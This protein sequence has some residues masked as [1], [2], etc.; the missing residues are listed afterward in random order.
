VQS[1]LDEI[2]AEDYLLE[3]LSHHTLASV[4]ERVGIARPSS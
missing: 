2:G 1:I 3:L 4:L